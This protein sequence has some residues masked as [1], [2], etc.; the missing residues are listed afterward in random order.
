MGPVRRQVK[1]S[2]QSAG[3]QSAGTP[4]T[5]TATDKECIV[6]DLLFDVAH[7]TVV[8]TGGLGQLGRQFALE[9]LARGA[10]VAIFSRR[11]PGADER[12][13]KFPSA[14]GNLEFF[15]V[16]VTQ[17]DTIAAGLDGVRERW[18]V[19]HVLVN[20][21]G[22]DS[23]PS[24]PPEENGPFETFPEET[25]DRV[26]EVNLK[27][28]FLCCQVV[29]GAMAAAG[30]GSIINIGSIY[31]VLSPVQDIYAYRMEQEGQPFIKPVA[32]SASKS[33]VMNL[34]RYLATYWAKKGVRVNTLVLSGV[35]RDTQ[36]ATFKRNYCERI[37]IGRMAREDEYNGAVVFLASDAS[38]Y[39]TGSTMTVDG[40]WSAW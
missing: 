14:G 6:N 2:W 40:G 29:G 30:R 11:L 37:P 23:Q 33:G 35:G 24:A 27:G 12:Q 10:R 38:I 1:N 32:Y 21:A 20:N 13:E 4:F 36:D 19:P 9:F 17:R 3:W 7:R 26:H 25:W 8:I 18:G 22:L 5:I 15:Q 28:V 16:D 39:M 31:G 34:T